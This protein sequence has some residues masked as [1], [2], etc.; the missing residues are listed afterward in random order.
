MDLGLVLVTRIV[1]L[2]LVNFREHCLSV[3]TA[4]KYKKGL[5]TY[6]LAIVSVVS[7][8]QRI[9]SQVIYFAL[10]WGRAVITVRYHARERQ[11]N[12]IREKVKRSKMKV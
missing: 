9:V 10:C 8:D 6:I 3:P 4:L 12:N 1:A 5:F 11:R 2:K 7:D